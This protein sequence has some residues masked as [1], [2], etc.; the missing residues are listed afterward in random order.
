[1]KEKLKTPSIWFISFARLVAKLSVS[2]GHL[3]KFKPI[4]NPYRTSW[5]DNS[6]G[7]NAMKKLVI[8]FS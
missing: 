3:A 8:I 6:T 1:M 4:D 2:S 7:K 5:E